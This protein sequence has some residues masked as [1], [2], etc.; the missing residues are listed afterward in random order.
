MNLRHRFSLILIVGLILCLALLGHVSLRPTDTEHTPAHI[1]TAADPPAPE[2]PPPA[3]PAAAP[4]PVSAPNVSP[5]SGTFR[6]RVVD[7][8]T[9]QPVREFELEFHSMRELKPGDAA[10][11]ARTFRSVDGRFEW[12]GIPP[13]RWMVTAKARGYQRFQIE[14]LAI[15]AGAVI[16][17]VMPLQRG[18]AVRGRVYDETSGAGIAAATIS[19]RE[20]H[21]DRFDENFWTRVR[22][23]T[24]K[25][26]SFVFDGVPQGSIIVSVSAPNYAGREIDAFVG[27]QTSPLQIALSVGGVVMGYLAGADGVTPIAGSVTIAHLDEDYSYGR[28]TSDAGEFKFEHLPPGRYQIVGGR[29]GQQIEREFSLAKD[30]RKDGLVLALAGGRSIRGV[31]TGVRAADLQRVNVRVNREGSLVDVGENPVDAMGGYEIRGVE[32]GQVIVSASVNMVRQISKTVQVPP[33]ADVTV[34]LEFP[35]GA[36]LTGN[37]THAGQPVANVWVRPQPLAKQD[38]FLYGARTSDKGEYVIEDVP[39]GKYFVRLDSYQSRTFEVSGDTVLNI[40][41]PV[42]QL[43]GRTVEEAGRVPVVGV[44]VDIWSP[45]SDSNRVWRSER[46]NHFG[47]FTF[48]GLEPGDYVVSAYKPGYEMYRDRISFGS[49]MDE[50]IIR[51]RQGKGVEIRMH[52]AVGGLPIRNAQLYESIGGRRGSGLVLHLDENGVGYIPRAL[53]GSTLKFHAPPYAPAVV[54]DW[55]GEELDLQLE[56][57]TAR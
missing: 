45:Q 13:R 52:E 56:Q 7:A 49:G 11:G 5:A 29:A 28:S 2:A 4:A 31:I 19:F 39:N 37:V 22:T 30:E 12:Q 15:S 23:T 20:A 51:L 41:V 16:E 35:R 18:H 42:A 44:D 57:Q 32:P 24:G 47:E 36:R 54:S 21:L 10:P 25:D 8:V 55:N 34:N 43:S 27:K 26:G 6:G 40:D 48:A 38:L 53:A 14:Q 9:R 3:Q 1:H 33:D 50:M 46:S 17:A